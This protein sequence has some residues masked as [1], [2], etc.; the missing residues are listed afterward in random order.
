MAPPSPRTTTFRLTQQPQQQGKIIRAHCC[1]N[2]FSSF[3]PFL[4]R[5]RHQGGGRNF[6]THCDT[7]A[8][9]DLPS[10]QLTV[11]DNKLLHT[12]ITSMRIP[13]GPSF[14]TV[15]GNIG[16]KRA[17]QFARTRYQASASLTVFTNKFQGD[18]QRLWNA[19]HH[20]LVFV[21]TILQTTTPEVH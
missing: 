4:D 17:A 19:E 2:H 7:N 8:G 6:S 18:C 20:P 15:F 16:G 9:G 13:A 1:C 3:I 12:G 10:C 5:R 21:A 11:A 14:T